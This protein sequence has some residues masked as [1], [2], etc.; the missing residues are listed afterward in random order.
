M[1]RFDS[2][3]FDSFDAKDYFPECIDGEPNRLEAI[4]EYVFVNGFL[5]NI[6]LA[7][8]SWSSLFSKSF[9][10]GSSSSSSLTYPKST[11]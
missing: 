6:L 11:V 4:S 7:S 2:G 5:L 3:L 9:D 1:G 10:S 8:L